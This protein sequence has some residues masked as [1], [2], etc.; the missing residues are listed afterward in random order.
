MAAILIRMVMH[1]EVHAVIGA[2]AMTSE[3]SE[4]NDHVGFHCVIWE[5]IS[6][7]TS[8]VIRKANED[9]LNDLA[10]NRFAI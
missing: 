4:G 8:T 5:Q 6:P 7:E 3:L 1:P 10:S 2:L 9:L